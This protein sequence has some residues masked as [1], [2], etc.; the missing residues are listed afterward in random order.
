[1][2]NV[3]S[4]TNK[5]PLE[6]PPSAPLSRLKFTD[7]FTGL[8][9]GGL[10]MIFASLESG[11]QVQPDKVSASR[12][13]SPAALLAQCIGGTAVGAQALEKA[14]LTAVG[15]LGSSIDP[16]VARAWAQATTTTI[17]EV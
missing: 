15:G 16:A 3:T 2:G 12:Q 10:A 11:G 14:L 4:R 17:G 5:Q 13:L 1:M 8:D 6:Q 7:A 9:A